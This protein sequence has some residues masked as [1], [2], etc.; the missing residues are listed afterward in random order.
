MSSTGH[1]E[2]KII[3]SNETYF[4]ERSDH[5]FQEPVDHHSIIYRH[6]DVIFNTSRVSCAHARLKEKQKVLTKNMDVLPEKANNHSVKVP[7]NTFH[8]ELKY[9]TLNNHDVTDDVHDDVIS[10]LKRHRKRRA[11][12]P[13][14]TTC[15]LYMQVNNAGTYLKLILE[16]MIWTDD[17]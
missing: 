7:V 14:K 5:Y 13:L 12:D 2:G 4:I 15:E 9:Q 3:T 1:F 11:V 6:S 10:E 17:N 8:E 16:F